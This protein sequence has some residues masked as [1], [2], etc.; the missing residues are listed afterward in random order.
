MALLGNVREWL[1]EIRRAPGI[2]GGKLRAFLR[3]LRWKL[4]I[5]I[6]FER[7]LLTIGPARFYCYPGYSGASGLLCYGFLEFDETAFTVR[8]LRP[9]DLFL[10]IGANIGTFSVI[11]GTFVPGVSVI[12]VEPG[13]D[14][15]RLLVENLG[16]SGLPTDRVASDVVGAEVGEVRFTKGLDV[17]NA[18]ATDDATDTVTLQQTT[19]DG[20]ATGRG[21]SL[22]KVDVEGM[23]LAV[24][25][26]AAKQL[27]LRPGPVILFEINGFCR[28]YGVE[29]EE[30]IDYL[31]DA[32]Y[33][34]FEYDGRA[35]ALTEYTGRGIPP[36]NNLVATTD[37]KMVEERLLTAQPPVDLFN[38]PVRAKLQR[39]AG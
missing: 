11:A 12:S 3:A 36:S 2:S 20:L 19:V 22:M 4:L 5:T 16:L 32:G 13:D 27:A 21:V 24:F 31:A 29:P 18:I 35:N 15:R 9:G 34:V 38:L 17:L 14:A 37:L 28:R 30:I 8:F 10:D 7:A 25:K 6:G 26:G 23:E 39:R 1:G 33:R